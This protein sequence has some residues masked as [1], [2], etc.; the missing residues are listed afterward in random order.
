[1]ESHYL[2]LTESQFAEAVAAL[3]GSS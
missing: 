3:K 2:P 1:M